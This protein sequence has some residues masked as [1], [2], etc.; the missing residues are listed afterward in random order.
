MKTFSHQTGTDFCVVPSNLE[1]TFYNIAIVREDRDK[2]VTATRLNGKTWHGHLSRALDDYE[3]FSE[4]A[5][6]INS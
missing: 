3:D 1:A 2:D 4:I 5:R 6:E